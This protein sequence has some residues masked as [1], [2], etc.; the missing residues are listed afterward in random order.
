[1]WLTK[2]KKITINIL[3]Y[4]LI[5]PLLRNFGVS[6]HMLLYL[7]IKYCFKRKLTGYRTSPS[8]DNGNHPN[9]C[10]TRVYSK[11]MLRS[12]DQM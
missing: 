2:N 11:L 1:M 12:I 4:Q 9:S 8:H 10:C 7:V 3:I 6:S 5:N